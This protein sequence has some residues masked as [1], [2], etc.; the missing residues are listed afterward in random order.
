[1]PYGFNDDKSKYDLTGPIV[2]S[3]MTAS[4]AYAEGEYV[5]ASGSLRRVDVAI[6]KGDAITDLNS[7]KTTI[8]DELAFINMTLRHI[9][10]A[11]GH[12]EFLGA[13]YDV[14]AIACCGIVY[15]ECDGSG[16]LTSTGPANITSP[17]IMQIPE[18]YRPGHSL[19]MSPAVDMYAQ[20]AIG[21]IVNA[22][23]TVQMT[24]TSGKAMSMYG[25]DSFTI[26]Y[27]MP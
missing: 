18:G 10:L 14:E 5:F 15:I 7:S 24:C 11:H 13:S 4:R 27:V 6:A 8:T 16:S 26:A 12:V 17:S 23:G 21:I 20:K 19:I 9:S 2:E 25:P 22:D 1:M 3:S